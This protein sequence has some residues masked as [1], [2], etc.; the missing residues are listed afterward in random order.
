MK[1]M[2]KAGLALLVAALFASALRGGSGDKTADLPALIKNGALL[3]D[4]RSAG[5]FQSGHAKGAINIPHDSID[6]VVHQHAPEKERA[7][8][9][10]C[11]SGNR[12]SAAK[13]SLARIGYTNV[14]NGGTLGNVKNALE[15]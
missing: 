3:I 9:V 11:R 10:Y 12:S 2:A 15:K 8:I 13:N 6:R 7:I 4:V 5:E 14:V 1:T